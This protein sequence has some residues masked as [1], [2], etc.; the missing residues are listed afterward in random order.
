MRT[1]VFVTID[2][3]FSIGGTF[4]SPM[5][6]QPIG[7]QNVDCLVRQRSEGLGFMLDTFA[8]QGIRATFFIETLQTAYFGDGPMCEIAH[9]I[10]GAGHD[11]QLHLHPVWT[12]FDSPQWQQRLSSVQPNDDLHGRSVE[13]LVAWMQRGIDTFNRWRLT[14]PVA[15]RT[16]NLMVDRNVYLA[17]AQVGL[18]VASNVARA[19]F[20]PTEPA[21]RFNTGIHDVEGV[22]E[23]PVLTYA[24]L[25]IGARTHRKVLTITGS[26]VSEMRCLLE[27]AHSAGATAVVLLTHCHEFVKG[28]LRGALAV[29]RVNQRRL[30]DIC[31]YLHDHGDRFEVTTM[32]RMAGLSRSAHSLSDPLLAVPAPLAALRMLQNKLNE[33]NLI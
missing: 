30:A 8:A 23:L 18:K 6:V 1:K 9:R 16:G 12:Y 5:S 15:L 24:D 14:S 20:E 2:T 4:Q 3:E 13:Q 28:D 33:L 27:R 29:D 11:L 25:E 17:M 10:G 26:S 31:R 22:V 21:L 32:D 19:V 7:A